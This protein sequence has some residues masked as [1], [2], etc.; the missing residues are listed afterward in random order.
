MTDHEL[1]NL[2][3]R[4][5]EHAYA[6]YSCFKVGAALEC[7]NGRV[8]TGCN[9]ENGALGSTICAERVAIC[10]AVSEGETKFTRIAIYADSADYCMPCGTCRQVMSEFSQDMEVLSANGAG[11]YV[12]YRLDQLL[13]HTFK[14]R[15]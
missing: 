2:A 14:L 15:S 9:V 4:A 7:E 8:F 10:K 1:L 6:P 3:I 12:S 13:P 11:S 5:S